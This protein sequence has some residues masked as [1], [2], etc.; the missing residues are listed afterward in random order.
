[1]S[2]LRAAVL[3]WLL[4]SVL[5]LALYVYWSPPLKRVAVNLV[6]M[7]AAGCFVIS[8]AGL[9]SIPTRILA[10]SHGRTLQFLTSV[11]LG[12]GMTGLLVFGL[13]SLGVL[14]RGVFALWTLAGIAAFLHAI[15]GWLKNRGEPEYSGPGN[16]IAGGTLLLFLVSSIPF[17]VAPELTTD[18]LEYHL[19]IPRIYL[20]TGKIGLIP[21][22]V[23]SNYPSLAEY[24]YVL[25]LSLTD[26]FVCKCF[27]YLA[28]VLLLILLG[29]MVRKIDPGSNPYWA[30]AMFVSMPVA[31]VQFG[32]AWNDLLYTFFILLSLYF[33]VCYRQAGPDARKDSDLLLAGVSAALGA[34]TKYTFVIFFLALLAL[35]WIAIKRWQWNPRKL[36]LLF[37]PIAFFIS[38]WAIKNWILTGN[39]VYPFLNEV[40]RSPLYTPEA[41]RYFRTSLTRYEFPDWGWAH[42]VFFPFYI[43]LKARIM[44][45]YT[46]VLPLVITPLLFFRSSSPGARMLKLLA[47]L[48]I[49]V[50]LFIQTY[51]RSLLCLLA[52]IFVVASVPLHRLVRRERPV[53]LAWQIVFGLAVVSNFFVTLLS[54][55]YLFDPVGFFLGRETSRQYV[56]RLARSQ[57]A[58]DWLNQRPD[59]RS[60]LLIGLH[61]PFYLQKHFVFSGCCDPPV[62][63]ALTAGISGAPQ[64]AAK[65]KKMG[66][67]HIVID[68]QE[69]AREHK[70]GLYSWPA[71]QRK[72]FEQ[73]VTE[74]CTRVEVSGRDVIFSLN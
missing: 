51:V 53:R 52:L 70:E 68:F 54:T 9:G 6:P 24:L 3:S 21:L 33:L 12:A 57:P 44:D 31:A 50:W 49:L 65:F 7:A 69:Y 37:A 11:A 1:M 23:E 60:V 20:S 10:R 66:I 59:V 22:L 27:H 4:L 40:F 2:R 41:Y 32:W 25:M 45:V 35:G 36:L 30:P 74:D 17:A 15:P 46:G 28:G 67:T 29:R 47:V 8:F 63:E 26:S 72:I 43:T 55:H 62:A 73:F 39:P 34:W 58:Y 48:Y 16:W 38:L 5:A 64:L 61:N 13:G 42:Q 19:L 14:S 56:T 71:E 18:A